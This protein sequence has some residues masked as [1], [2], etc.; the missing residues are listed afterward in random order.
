VDDHDTLDEYY[1]AVKTELEAWA[2]LKDEVQERLTECRK[3]ER[4]FALD[5]NDCAKLGGEFR[6]LWG[7]P[8]TRLLTTAGPYASLAALRREKRTLSPLFATWA[9]AEAA[10][11]AH[12]NASGPVVK[13]YAT[14][15]TDTARVLRDNKVDPGKFRELVTD[16]IEQRI[17]RFQA[18]GPGPEN[19]VFFLTGQRAMFIALRNL[20]DL[21]CAGDVANA[22]KEAKL[23]ASL[24]ANDY[25]AYLLASTLTMLQ[26]TRNG[27]LL[28][29]DC[30]VT[31]RPDETKVFPP[32]FWA[33]S[34]VFKEKP[35]TVD[36]GLAA[37]ERAA[38]WMTLITLMHAVAARHD[39]KQVIDA[40]IKTAGGEM[41]SAA[42]RKL[43]L[44]K[45]LDDA[46]QNVLGLA[47]VEQ[48]GSQAN[49]FP[50]AFLARLIESPKKQHARLLAMER[51][52]L[53]RKLVREGVLGESADT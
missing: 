2:C 45:W 9:Q 34:I 44:G 14:R 11:D 41:D 29:K 35:E 31:H 18:S 19:V 30:D 20:V 52:T 16:D 42:L 13:R 32:K 1:S 36:F 38:K 23:L 22:R 3:D 21:R 33:G 46:L 43:T 48:A 24:K 5:V 8:I 15:Q 47:T 50:A 27:K 39:S 4:I 12:K 49:R 7:R 6:E 40:V 28:R 17:K 51:L 26:N 25:C 53:V 37:A 10:Y